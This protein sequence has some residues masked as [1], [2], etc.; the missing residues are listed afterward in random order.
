MTTIHIYVYMSILNLNLKDEI[1]YP[2]KDGY[3]HEVG[4]KSMRKRVRDMPV[5]VPECEHLSGT[6]LFF[7][8]E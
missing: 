7:V 4:N 1:F 5:F 3:P 2:L 6:H 8:Q